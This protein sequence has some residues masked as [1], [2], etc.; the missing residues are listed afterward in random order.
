VGV[1][2]IDLSYTPETYTAGAFPWRPMLNMNTEHYVPR[3]K[4]PVT[5]L[6]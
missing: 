6:T 2:I 1:I 3:P 5:Q 4:Q